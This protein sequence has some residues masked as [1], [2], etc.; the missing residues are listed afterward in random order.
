MVRIKRKGGQVVQ[1]CD[2]YIGRQWSMGGWKSRAYPTEG[3]KLERS[4][5]C[6][7]FSVKKYGREKSLEMYEEYVRG[8]S[9]LMGRLGELK[10][11]TL[12]CWC[13]PL[14]CHGDV[15]VKLVGERKEG[16]QIPKKWY[17]RSTIAWP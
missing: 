15:L 2:V 4:I 10:G 8:N 14:A 7:P 1:G 13:K 16:K 3:R 12:G 6:N 11:C 9:D 5:W 17:I